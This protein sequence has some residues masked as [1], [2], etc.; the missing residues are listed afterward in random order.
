ME[1]QAVLL[2]V[3]GVAKL[4]FCLFCLPSSFSSSNMFA[5]SVIVVDWHRYAYEEVMI[6]YFGQLLKFWREH[7]QIV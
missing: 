2:Q 1:E 4:P 3:V 6:G 5:F 7:V